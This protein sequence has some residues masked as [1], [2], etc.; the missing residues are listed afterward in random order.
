MHTNSSLLL[1]QGNI[2]INSGEPSY[3]LLGDKDEEKNYQW[4]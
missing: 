1:N 2:Y 3:A 4:H